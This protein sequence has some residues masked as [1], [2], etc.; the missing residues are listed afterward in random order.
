[1]RE[2]GEAPEGTD[3]ELLARDALRELVGLGPI[4]PL[5]EDEETLEIHVARP[6]YVLAVKGGQPMLA[7]PSFT[8][9]EA[10]GRVVARL[11]HQSGEPW[12]SG[13][14]RHRATARARGAHGGDRSAGG[15]HLGR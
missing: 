6:D 9:E 4:G 1:M 14:A 2:E 13:R 3:L 7:D 12:Q 15:E 5:L 10:L 8:S 11:A